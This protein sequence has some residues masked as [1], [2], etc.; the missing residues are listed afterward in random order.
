MTEKN[1][2]S[3]ELWRYSVLAIPVA[4]AG[5]P[6]YVL[7]PDYYATTHGVSLSLLGF[8][9]L[10]LRL[11]DAIQ[12]PFI[13]A[14]SDRYR[15]VS[16]WFMS[17]SA[18]ILCISIYGLFNLM[19]MAPAVWFCLCVAVAVSAYSVLSINLNTLGGLWIKNQA[20][21]M[22][23]AAVRESLGTAFL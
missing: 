20:A 22:R 8:L 12:D 13:G 23:I 6:L 7:A 5:F 9:L 11:F 4:F 19:P 16:K 14:L 3:A 10:G 18:V 17:A 21:Q 15:D 1:I 2:R